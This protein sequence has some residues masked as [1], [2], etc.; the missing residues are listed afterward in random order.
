MVQVELFSK[1]VIKGLFKGPWQYI[2]PIFFLKKKY[3]H[4]LK[5]FRIWARN[6]KY[7]KL[8]QLLLEL[9]VKIMSPSCLRNVNKNYENVNKQLTL[10]CDS[11][12]AM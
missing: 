1:Y 2:F 11:I 8:C 9:E 10:T 7:C 12:D 3:L 5:Y 4:L 6:L